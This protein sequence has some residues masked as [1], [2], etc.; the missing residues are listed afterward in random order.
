[1][2]EHQPVTL[3]LVNTACYPIVVEK[4]IIVVGLYKPM[5][6]ALE[7]K[8]DIVGIGEEHKRAHFGMF[9]QIAEVGNIVL[10]ME[11]PHGERAELV[12]TE[13]HKRTDLRVSVV[14][15]LVGESLN[16]SLS[17]LAYV[18]AVVAF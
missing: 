18:L 13:F 6:H 3:P 1:M 10:H 12:G 14:D 15:G 2:A 16:A 7:C 9:Y 11:R 5:I 4:D 8:G 17:V